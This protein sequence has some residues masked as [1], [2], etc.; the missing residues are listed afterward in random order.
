MAEYYICELVKNLNIYLQ[1]YKSNKNS[2]Q[3]GKIKPEI[4]KTIGI[5]NNAFSI[6]LAEFYDN[7]ALSV[8]S[9]LEAVNQSIKLKGYIK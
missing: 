8:S 2:I 5:I 3:L 7:M 1:I 6:V 9:S 4:I